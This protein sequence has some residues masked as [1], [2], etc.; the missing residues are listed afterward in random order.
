MISDL[1]L[2]LTVALISSYGDLI[3]T[4][5]G[6]EIR[7]CQCHFSTGSPDDGEKE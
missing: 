7:S 5:N 1:V 2:L 4:L 3:I 6:T